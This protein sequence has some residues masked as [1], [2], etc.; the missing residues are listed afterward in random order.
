MKEFKVLAVVLAVVAALYIGVEPFAHSKLH[1]KVSP[2]D[3]SFKDLEKNTLSGNVA[4]GKN[5]IVNNYKCQSCHSISSQKL[6]ASIN[7]GVIAPDLSNA[8][9]IYDKKFL[10][11]LIKNPAIATQTTHKFSESNPHPMPTAVSDEMSNQDIADIVAYLVDIAPKIKDV[12][13]KEVFTQACQRC[14]GIK[15]ADMIKKTMGPLS[16]VKPYLGVTPPD[17]SQFIRSRSKSYLNEFINEPNKHLEGTAMPRVGLNKDAQAKVI[18]YL[19][20]IGDSKK[21]ERESIGIYFLLYLLILA[22]FAWAWKIKV[23]KEVH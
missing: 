9:A 16:D 12:S 5:L 19:E 7:L 22:I 20:E 1:K 3:F 8:G 13:N 6:G 2:A 10:F 11:A 23:W 14:H 21:A 17:L 15:Y 4:N 18:M